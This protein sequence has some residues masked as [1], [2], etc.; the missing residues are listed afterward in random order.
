METK[1]LT[2][3]AAILAVGLVVVSLVLALAHKEQEPYGQQQILTVMGT[4]EMS[5]APDKV[6][7][8][9][10][11]ETTMP[12]AKDAQ[13]KNAEAINKV[14]ADLAAAGIKQT[15][16]ATDSYTIYPKEQ[17]S[18]KLQKSELVGYTAV[19]VLKV[20]TSNTAD[21]GK[22]IDAAV[23]AGANRIDRIIFG[24]TKEKEKQV[25]AELL[26]L[27]GSNAKE[28]AASIASTMGISLGKVASISESNYNV[29]PVPIYYGKDLSYAGGAE[30]SSISPRNIEASAYIT[31]AYK[32]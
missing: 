23:N 6:D 20:T 28:K 25:A 2:Y 15:D 11:V 12:T 13:A 21:A 24:L 31:V 8:Y 5:V 1:A 32:I 29:A 22:Y 10:A 4:S 7:M 17:W 9:I 30:S 27:A 3:M 19:N 14:M 16:I 26:E 18:D